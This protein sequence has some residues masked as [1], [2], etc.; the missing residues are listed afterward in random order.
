MKHLEIPSMECIGE[1]GTQTGR[2]FGSESSFPTI[3]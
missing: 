2:E 1:S 3:G